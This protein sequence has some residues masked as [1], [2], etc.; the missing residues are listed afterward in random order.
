[1]KI[2]SQDI[3]WIV[4]HVVLLAGIIFGI[5]H[6]WLAFG[7]WFVFRG[8]EPMFLKIFMLTGPLS[9]LPAS[10]T[11]FF[12]PKIGSMWLICGSVV[13]FIAVMTDAVPKRDFDQIVWTY[14]A[15]ML[16]LGVLA[17]FTIKRS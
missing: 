4:R 14:C 5:R 2:Q 16:V 8:D 11:A 17:L 12:R 3:R 13:S 1:M 9:T 6:L 10:I 15:P 7:A